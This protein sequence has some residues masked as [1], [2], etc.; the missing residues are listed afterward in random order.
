MADMH[1][2]LQ[3]LS[4]HQ[5]FEKRDRDN[6]APGIDLRRVE[7]HQLLKQVLVSNGQEL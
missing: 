3:G 1:Q 6:E 7:V 2:L 5:V 4:C